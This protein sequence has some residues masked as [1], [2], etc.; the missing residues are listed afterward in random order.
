M[1]LIILISNSN[2][3]KLELKYINKK[4]ITINSKQELPLIRASFISSKG[5]IFTNKNV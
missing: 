1:F 2:F 3:E 4:L 5:R